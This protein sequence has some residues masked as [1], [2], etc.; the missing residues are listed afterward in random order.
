MPRRF[1]LLP[2]KKS[3]QDVT[4]KVTQEGMFS[5]KT[6]KSKISLPR[7]S[8]PSASA[9]SALFLSQ[10]RVHTER[11]TQEQQPRGAGHAH[12]QVTVAILATLRKLGLNHIS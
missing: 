12:T 3:N 5:A 1:E 8:A 4:A 7:T 11:R 10:S 6:G 2:G 9:S